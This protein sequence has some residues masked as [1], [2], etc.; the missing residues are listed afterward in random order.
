MEVY[1]SKQEYLTGSPV[2]EKQVA[3]ILRTGNKSFWLTHVEVQRQKGA[4]DFVLF[5]MAH[6]VTL[7]RGRPPHRQDLFR[8]HLVKC[9]DSSFKM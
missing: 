2:L 3:K 5:A 1:N 6:A 8:A 4:Y 7:H 9:F